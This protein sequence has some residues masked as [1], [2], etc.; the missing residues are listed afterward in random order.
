[1]RDDDCIRHWVKCNKKVWNLTIVAASYERLNSRMRL[2]WSATL[3]PI[4]C[5]TGQTDK[6]V[7]TVHVEGF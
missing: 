5:Y 1:M 2:A 3:P 7:S 4:P 6:T